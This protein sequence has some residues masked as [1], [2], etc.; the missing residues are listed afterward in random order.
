MSEKKYTT[1]VILDHS[2][3][4]PTWLSYVTI[5]LGLGWFITIPSTILFLY[6]ASGVPVLWLYCK[7]MLA[8]FVGIVLLSALY[9]ADR[10]YQPNIAFTFG[11][12]VMKNSIPYYSFKME[13]EDFDAVEKAGPSLFAIEPHGVFPIS[14]FWGSL[15]ILP[16]HKLL[17]CLSSTMFKLPMTKHVL[18][19][20]GA[21]SVD[22][23]VI[24]KSLKQGFSLNICPGGVQEVQYLGNKDELVLFLKS[25]LGI[26]K[27]AMQQGVCLIPS[28]TF[29]L[30]NTYDFWMFSNKYIVQFGRQLGFFPMV[31]FG[32]GGIPFSQSK[33]CPLAVVVGK[34]LKFPKIDNPTVEDIQKCHDLF[35]S[36]MEKLYENNKDRY[37]MSNVKLRII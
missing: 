30:Q 10:E 25:R 36:A 7:Y 11:T 20:T 22:K 1:Q 6:L 34:P 26:T 37:G 21:V 5:F 12:W 23:K 16:H 17:C 2:H 31:F 24:E 14:M 4:K 15:D 13:F 32:V 35:L 18:C 28:I 8:G 9:P 3:V 19:W 29:G 27:I 33:P